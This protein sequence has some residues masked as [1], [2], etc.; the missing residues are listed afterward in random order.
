[1]LPSVHGNKSDFAVLTKI[2]QESWYENL[3]V[4]KFCTLGFSSLKNC[5]KVFELIQWQVESKFL[6]KLGPI[7]F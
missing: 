5:E 7:Y 3:I 4:Y 1:M 2:Q 6:T